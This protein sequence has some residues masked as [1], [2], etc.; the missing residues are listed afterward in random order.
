MKKNPKAVN[1]YYCCG[2]TK[3]NE[4]TLSHMA[5][6]D[7]VPC[8]LQ[9]IA[10]RIE[11]RCILDNFQPGEQF[12]YEVTQY[13]T[14][15][16][17]PT[18]TDLVERGIGS[19]SKQGRVFTLDRTLPLSCHTGLTNSKIEFDDDKK[20]FI[21]TYI[22]EDYRELFALKNTIIATEVGGCP[23]PVELQNNTLLGRLNDT[24]QSIDQQE[25]WSIILENTR[26]PIQGMIRYNKKDKCFEGYDGKKWRALM[27]GEK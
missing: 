6:L 18:N 11:G 14:A 17:S 25:L 27:W 5:D 1:N 21:S 2:I 12:F 23:S 8:P 16:R 20:L 7:D 9:Y 24:I 26:K 4:I 22:P 13:K 3:D 19:I 15:K 10:S